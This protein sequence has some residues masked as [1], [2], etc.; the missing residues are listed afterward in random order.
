MHS[1]LIR[2]RLDCLTNW[3]T[4]QLRILI[5]AQSNRVLNR[6]LRVIRLLKTSA[7]IAMGWLRWSD[8]YASRF[9]D[10]AIRRPSLWPSS[11]GW[12]FSLRISFATFEKTLPWAEFIFR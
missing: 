6:W 11:A 5:T 10:I 3:P 2:F 4:V 12:H 1:A 9:S 8:W 7:N